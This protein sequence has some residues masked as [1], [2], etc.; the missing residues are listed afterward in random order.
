MLEAVLVSA[1]M[2]RIELE[3]SV[4]LAVGAEGVVQ[5]HVA[6]DLHVVHAARVSIPSLVRHCPVLL[7]VSHV[8]VERQ[9]DIAERKLSLSSSKAMLPS[10]L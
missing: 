6:L 10:A 4:L 9:M 5:I 7:R 2:Q 3:I 8:P 1:E